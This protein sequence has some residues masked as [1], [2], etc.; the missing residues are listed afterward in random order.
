[1][2]GKTLGVAHADPKANINENQTTIEFRIA[3]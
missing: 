1:M 3:K 2:Q